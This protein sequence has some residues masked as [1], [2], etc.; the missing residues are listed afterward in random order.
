M[1]RV[2]VTKCSITINGS[3]KNTEKTQKEPMTKSEG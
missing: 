3:K 1:I 2:L